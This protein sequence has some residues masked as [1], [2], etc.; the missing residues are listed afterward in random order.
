[1]RGGAWGGVGGGGVFEAEIEQIAALKYL[2]N[3]KWY[4]IYP[5]CIPGAIGSFF[6]S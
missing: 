4:M 1:M 2:S 5:L 6:P 3:L